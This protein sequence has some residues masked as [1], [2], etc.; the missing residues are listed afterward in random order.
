[1]DKKHPAEHGKIHLVTKISLRSTK[2]LVLHFDLEQS[3]EH[4]MPVRNL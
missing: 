2:H 4:N 3:E 1:M